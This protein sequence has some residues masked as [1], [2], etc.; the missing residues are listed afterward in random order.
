MQLQWRAS[1]GFVLWVWTHSDEHQV[2]AEGWT[3]DHLVASLFHTLAYDRLHHHEVSGWDGHPHTG[4]RS[5]SS[6]RGVGMRR[7]ST[8]WRTIDFI[9]TRCRDEMDVHTLAYDRLHHHE[10]SG[11]DG[12]PHTGVRST[13][14]SRGVGMRRTSTHWHTIDFI[15]TR[16]R[17]EMDVHTLAYDRL[18]HHKVSG[19]DGHPHTGVRSTSSSRGVG[20]RRTSTHWRTIDFIITRCRDEMDVHTLAYDRLHHHEVSGWD[21]HPHTGVRST[22]SS[23]GVG[24]RRTSTHWHTIDFII[25]RCR[26]EMDVHT[27]AYDRLHHHKVSGWDGHPHTGVRSTSSSWGVGMRRTSTHWRTIDFIITRCRDEMDIH[28]L[29]YDRHH[30]HEVSGWDGYPHT[31]VWSTSSPRGVDI[32]TLAYDR[33]HHHEVSTSTHWRTI[34]IIITRCRDETD[35]HTLAYDRHHHHEVSGWD[36][37][38]HTGVRSTSSRG[39]GMRRTSTHWRTIDFIITRCRDET[40]IHTLA[41]N[42]LHHHEVSGWDGHPHTGVRLTS[43]SRGVG[44]RRTSTHWCTIDFIIMRCRDETDIHTLVYDWLHHHEVSGWDGH[45]H[46]GVQSTSSSWG[47]GMRRTSTHWRTIDFIITRCR[48]ETDIH[49]LAYDRLHHHEVSGWD[50]HPHT[51]VRSTSSSRGVGMRRTSTHWRTIDFIITRCR[52]DTDV[53]TLAYDWLHHHE[54]SGWDG[55]PHTGV[56]STS[57]SRVVGMRRTSTLPEPC[58]EQ[59]ATGATDSY[60]QKR[61]SP[62][63]SVAN[64]EH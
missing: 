26:D 27:L 43:S 38:P 20:M 2:Q 50:G 62:P 12:H 57:S 59:T 4:V 35:I 58:V 47:V 10:V 14:S 8:H 51:G 11:W 19:W 40:D 18:H 63:E 3:Q 54:V 53:H 9:I 15:I 22:S 41:Y 48:D 7:T 1:T 17:D 37:H 60:E 21:G 64:Q 25:T 36:G 23:R 30:H 33:L 24:M 34:D 13:S 16:C 45:P 29:A 42:R 61:P 28:T 32:H 46:T 31:G 5:T 52:D 56:R 6:S 55:R 49:T 39:F 44:M